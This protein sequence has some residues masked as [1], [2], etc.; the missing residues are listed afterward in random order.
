MLCLSETD[1]LIASGWRSIVRA[2]SGMWGGAGI[3]LV[4]SLFDHVSVL[5]SALN[6]IFRLIVVFTPLLLIKD[7]IK[8]VRSHIELAKQ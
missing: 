6:Q 4:C 3:E 1:R 5:A 7:V 8:S 2:A